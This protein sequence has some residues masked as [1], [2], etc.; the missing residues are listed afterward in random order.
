M[1]DSRIMPFIVLVSKDGKSKFVTSYNG[2][3]NEY[4]KNYNVLGFGNTIDEA[5]RHLY[6]DKLE[7]L[8]HMFDYLDTMFKDMNELGIPI[9]NEGQEMVQELMRSRILKRN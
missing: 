6:K 7:E 4:T 3:Y 5:R 1:T 8:A 9:S 2:W